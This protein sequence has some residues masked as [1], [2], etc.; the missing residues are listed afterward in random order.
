MAA[1]FPVKLIQLAGEGC[2]LR[3]KIGLRA[4][5]GRQ[6]ASD[7]RH[8][9]KDSERQPVVGI[10]YREGIERRQ[11]EEIVGHHAEEAR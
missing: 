5:A 10:G 2:A 11:E 6:I 4:H 1:S 7:D 3:R 8:E 9:K